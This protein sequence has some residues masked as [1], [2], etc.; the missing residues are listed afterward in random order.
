MFAARRKAPPMRGRS[1]AKTIPAPTLGW[2]ARDALA[3]MA[4][5]DAVSLENMF[6]SP[7]AVSVRLGYTEWATGIPATVETIFQY[8]GGAT[9]KQFAAADSEIYDTTAGGAVGAASVTGLTNARWQYVNNTTAA[10]SYLQAVNGADKMIVF[11]GTNWHEDGDGAPYDVTGVNT[12]TC[13]GI[14]LS[15]NRVWFVQNAS[16]KAWYLPTGAIG[17]AANALDLSSIFFRGGYLMAMSTWTM[18]AGYGMDDMTAF[19]TSEGEVAVYRGSDPSSATTWALVGVFWMGSPIGRRC[20]IKFAG[21]LLLITQDGVVSMASALQSSRVNPKAALSYKIQY[22]ISTAICDHGS[23]YGWQLLQFPRQNMLILNV[24]IQEGQNQQQYVMSTIK[25]GNGDWAWC[26]FTGWQASCWELYGDDIY[27]GGI[28]FVGKAWNG[29]DDNGANINANGLQAFNDLGS[30][31]A[32]KRFTMMRPILQ[33]D[34]NPAILGSVNVDFDT[35]DPTS[36]LAFTGTSYALWDVALWDAG[37]WAGA[38]TVLKNWNGCTGV[39]YWVA[40]RLKTASMGI[41]IAWVNT[42]L[43]YESGGII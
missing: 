39:G 15:H 37:L 41:Q 21:D 7:T 4:P 43:V 12:A 27:F 25:R 28:G 32:Q 36:P 13:I 5:Q 42:T 30:D 11:D 38:I 19:I 20:A 40:P 23:N 34:G 18:D 16:L 3:N 14:C 17:G 9:Q 29:Y 26:N 6:P 22:A 35:S 2:N 24:P 33:S 31:Q 10:G 8:S 1:T